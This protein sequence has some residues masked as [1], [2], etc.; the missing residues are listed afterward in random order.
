MILPENTSRKIDNLGR[1][2]IPKGLRDRLS[3]EENDEMELFTG[4]IEGRSYILLSR[5]VDTRAQYK[6]SAMEYLRALDSVELRDVL[7]ELQG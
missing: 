2:T 1:I 4:E 7:E 6:K 3:L 5:P